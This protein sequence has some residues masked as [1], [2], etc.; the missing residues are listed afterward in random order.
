[1]AIAAYHERREQKHFDLAKNLEQMDQQQLTR[2]KGVPE[3]TLPGRAITRSDN[4][5]WLNL[6]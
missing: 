3:L 1:M 6:I 2:R 4:E 5:F